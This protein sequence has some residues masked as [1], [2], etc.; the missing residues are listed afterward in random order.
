MTTLDT[1]SRTNCVICGEPLGGRVLPTRGGNRHPGCSPFGAVEAVDDAPGDFP[2]ELPT[3]T[4]LEEHDDAPIVLVV[5]AELS[6]R[7]ED[8]AER[9]APTPA[10]DTPASCFTRGEIDLQQMNR[11]ILAE[12]PPEEKRKD[13]TMTKNAIE[14]IDALRDAAEAAES[15][16]ANAKAE[17]QAAIA[18]RRDA[19]RKELEE[20]DAMYPEEEKIAR[21]VRR[22]PPQERKQHTTGAD[23]AFDTRVIA[24]LGKNE[25]MALSEIIGML[26]STKTAVRASLS[27][28]IDAGKVKQ[29]GK[30]RGTKYEAA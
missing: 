14:S 1:S 12:N 11:E 28:L 16:A 27:R 23:D 19:L 17:F 29:R 5:D 2:P 6:K 13:T 26:G 3:A 7:V 18:E 25:S 21:P 24:L 22:A 15:A 20:L 4:E 8:L 9:L 10:N 30:F